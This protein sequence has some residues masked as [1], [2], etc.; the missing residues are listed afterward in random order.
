M[1]GQ[2]GCLPCS[3]VGSQRGLF[4]QGVLG[5]YTI[6]TTRSAV[7]QEEVKLTCGTNSTITLVLFRQETVFVS[8][9]RF[10]AKKPIVG[11][12]AHSASVIWAGPRFIEGN[13]QAPTAHMSR[14]IM[15]GTHTAGVTLACFDMWSRI[16]NCHANSLQDQATG[17]TSKGHNQTAFSEPQ[18]TYEVSRRVSRM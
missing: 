13:A 15:A 2:T 18:G 14:P 6:S 1:H 12:I 3:S 16:A 4:R 10:M 9:P 11:R 7:R 5:R 8:V 17:E